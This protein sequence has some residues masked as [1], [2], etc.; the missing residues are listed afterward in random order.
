MKMN[1][2]TLAAWLCT[3]LIVPA[4]VSCGDT[5]TTVGEDTAAVTGGETEV[6]TEAVT[7][8]P[9]LEGAIARMEGTDFGG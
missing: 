6:V 5:T 1:K 8:A 4:V 7:E 9:T 2:R 3:L